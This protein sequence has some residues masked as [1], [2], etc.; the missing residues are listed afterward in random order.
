MIRLAQ[1]GY[2]AVGTFGSSP[3][4]AQ[5]RLLRRFPGGVWLAPDNDAEGQKFLKRAT[6]YLKRYVPVYHI[7]VVPGEKADLSDLPTTAAIHTHHH[8]AERVA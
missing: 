4:D 5:L 6:D 7:P 1:A 2:S 3:N 8:H